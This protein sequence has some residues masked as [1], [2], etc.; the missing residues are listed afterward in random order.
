[1]QLNTLDRWWKD[2]GKP[3]V[4]FIK[5][6]TQG[7]ELSILQGGTDLL[8]GCLGCEVEVEFTALYQGQPLFHEID[9]YLREQGFVLW[10]LGSLCHYSERPQGRMNREEFICYEST[11]HRFPSG[12]GRLF[13]GN[14]IYFRDY[15][16]MDLWN[17]KKALCLAALLEAAGDLDGASAC[18]RGI[19]KTHPDS[20]HEWSTLKTKIAQ[21]G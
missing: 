2:A 14:A 9:R 20:S 3:D 10:R 7:S 18:L 1:L 15:A 6:D 16:Q 12:S 19:F 4:C 8:K 17:V 13:W 5:L 21:I 11:W